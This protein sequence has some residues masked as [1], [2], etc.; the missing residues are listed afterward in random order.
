[1]SR[2]F[3]VMGDRTT[4]GG[5]V[6]SADL[7]STIHGKAMARVGDSVVCPKCKGVFR[8]TTCADDMFDGG[9]LG[10]ARHMDSTDCGARLIA[11]QVTATWSNQS[12]AGDPA[13]SE[14]AGAASAAAQIAAPTQSGICLDCLRKAAN[15]GSATVIRA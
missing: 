9:G 8:I 2:P 13:S 1:M 14:M 3:I 7:T 5:T 15:L 6:I 11:S 10:Y 4:H 12:P